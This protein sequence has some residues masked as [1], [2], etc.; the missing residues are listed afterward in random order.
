MES[1][2]AVIIEEVVNRVVDVLGVVTVA[3]TGI[4]NGYSLTFTIK[5]N[6]T[7]TKTVTEVII[8]ITVDL[9][10]AGRVTRR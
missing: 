3:T 5:S 1:S 10:V 7:D 2:V 8:T 9:I 6:A 4:Q